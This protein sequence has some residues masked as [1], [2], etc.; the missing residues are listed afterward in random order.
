MQRFA[1]PGRAYITP[2]TRPCL[3]EPVIGSGVITQEDNPRLGLR[4]FFLALYDACGEERGDYMDQ[5]LL[6]IQE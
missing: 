3:Q 6:N 2:W 5:A 4:T 1:P